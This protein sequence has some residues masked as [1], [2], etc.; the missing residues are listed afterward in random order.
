MVEACEEMREFESTSHATAVEKPNHYSNCETQHTE[1][2]STRVKCDFPAI[3]ACI[4]R[5]ALEIDACANFEVARINPSLKLRHG[6]GTDAA[7]LPRLLHDL[8]STLH[9]L[10]LKK[11]ARVQI[12]AATKPGQVLHSRTRMKSTMYHC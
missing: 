5:G 3:D 7:A 6:L 1:Q 10:Q 4:P 12:L 11:L 9:A 8:Q 2:Y